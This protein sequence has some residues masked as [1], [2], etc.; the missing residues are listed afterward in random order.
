MAQGASGL[1]L[2][3]GA[4]KHLSLSLVGQIQLQ[5]GQISNSETVQDYCM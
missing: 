1:A 4:L 3:N 5:C 2:E